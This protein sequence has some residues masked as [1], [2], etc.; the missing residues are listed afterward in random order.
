MGVASR[1]PAADPL[2]AAISGDVE[3]RAALVRRHGGLIWGLC[4]RLTADPEDAWQEI[5]EKALRALPRFDPS[6]PARFSTWLA[7][8]A[9]RHLV[10]RHRRARVRGEQ[11]AV[12][13]LAAVGPGPEEVVSQGE[14][15]AR[16][17]AA[18][19]QL[20]EPWRRVVVAHHLGE[21]PLE[22]IAEAE[23]L[24]IGTVKSRLHR[25]R[26]ALVSILGGEL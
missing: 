11:V 19:A 13:P 9:H 26:A 8:L 1:A 16:L 7:T 4:A 10:D 2:P 20:P 18:L 25:G 6:G 24:P 17:E 22:A 15:A 3:A 14:R 5:W 12:E 23:G 21:L